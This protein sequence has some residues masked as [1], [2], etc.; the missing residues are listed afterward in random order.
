MSE[1]L[2][3]DPNNGCLI[4]P[5]GCNYENEREAAHYALL[6]LCGCGTPEAAFNFCR[7]AL[8]LFDRRGCHDKPPTKD[9]INAEDALRDLIAKRPEDA[10]HVLAHLLT[11]LDLLEH[12]GG[13][14]GSWLTKDGERVVDM[15]PMPE[16]FL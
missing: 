10:A 5:D 11:N 9:W 16:D 1:W 12:G 7:D 14:G 3:R 4:G 6:K 13:V 15:G 2:K 8:S